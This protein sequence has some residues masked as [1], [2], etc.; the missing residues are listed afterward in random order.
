MA[1]QTLK[2]NPETKSCESSPSAVPILSIRDLKV[3]FEEVSGN[4]IQ[5]VRGVS[6]DLYQGEILGLVGETGSGKSVSCKAITQLLPAN[7]QVEGSAFYGG[8]D[9]LKV[10]K[11]DII[12]YRGK[13]ISMIFQ[14]PQSS[15]NPIKNIY[16]HLKEVLLKD[17]KS[18]NLKMRAKQQLKDIHIKSPEK[19]LYNYP[20]QFSGGMAQRVQI[21]M[22]MIGQPDVLIADEPTTALDVTIQ[23]KIL[24]ELRNL[25]NKNNLAVIFVTHDLAVVAE[26]CDRIAVMYHGQIVELGKT[27]LVLKS[28]RH[29]YTQALLS[30]VPVIG[31]NRKVLEPIKGDILPAYLETKGCDF[32]ERCFFSQNKCHKIKPPME[33]LEERQYRCFYPLTDSVQIKPDKKLAYVREIKDLALLKVENLTC[34]FK[35]H[36][37]GGS[38]YFSAVDGVSFNIKK[39]EIFGIVGESGSGKSTLANAIMGLLKPFAGAISFQG[40]SLITGEWNYKGYTSQIQYVFQDPLGALDPRMTI[41]RQVMEP[42]I[43]HCK[44]SKTERFE[45]AK[46]ILN[47]CGINDSMFDRKPYNLSGGQRQRIVLARALINNPKL[48]ICD[49]PV[50]A[51]DVSVQAQILNLIKD[52]AYQKEISVLFISHDLSVINNIC[53][54]VAVM[55]AGQ[56]VEMGTIDRVFQTPLHSYTQLLMDSIPQM[57]S[58]QSEKGFN[59]HLKNGKK[60]ELEVCKSGC[61][62]A[63]RCPDVLDLCFHQNPTWK[64]P[65]V[66]H[67]VAC[68]AY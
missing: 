58:Y 45:R 41:I 56:F 11:H 15:L 48:L 3:R 6:F 21:A 66:N 23:A 60:E 59:I 2:K 43:I 9:L 67:E 24:N 5:A 13:G 14:D 26:I 34:R 30:S 42:L 12:K 64:S 31:N 33:E 47:Q 16:S 36:G 44:I 40:K 63:Y 62:Y 50:S 39:G 57:D 37:K 1:I 65:G 29:P 8:V 4:S 20:F 54:R 17:K 51:M 52:L 55:F 10:K 18:G 68:H 27:E 49:E 22:A 32:A 53:D 38:E 28:P 7:A 19:R 46:S 35:I 61:S 25:C